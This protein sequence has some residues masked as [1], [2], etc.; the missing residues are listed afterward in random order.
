[1]RQSRLTISHLLAR[2]FMAVALLVGLGFGSHPS[3]GHMS[4]VHAAAASTLAH[5]HPTVA[6]TKADALPHHHS[7]DCCEPTQAVQTCLSAC[8]AFACATS[9]LPGG[10]AALHLHATSGV[11]PTSATF[12]R[13]RAPDIETPPPKARL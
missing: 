3:I 8:A 5:H 6:S 1:M 9:V 2:L 4:P 7:D 12:L 10:A 13:S 11:Q